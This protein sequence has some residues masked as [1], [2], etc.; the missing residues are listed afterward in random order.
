MHSSASVS[1]TT[2][3]DM[4]DFSGVSTNDLA[5]LRSQLFTSLNLSSCESSFKPNTAM[6]TSNEDDE[7]WYPPSPPIYDVTDKLI[8]V[9]REFFNDPT[10]TCHLAGRLRWKP[11][12][13]LVQIKWLYSS[14]VCERTNYYHSESDESSADETH[15]SL[16]T[17]LAM[18]LNLLPPKIELTTIE[19]VS[20]DNSEQHTITLVEPPSITFQPPPEC[21]RLLQRLYYSF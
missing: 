21:K 10:S 3:Y 12:D 19:D 18:R 4:Y 16:A 11:D 17:H 2:S 8:E 9:N 7:E 1:S 13:N 20:P 15:D 14:D 5:I 6:D